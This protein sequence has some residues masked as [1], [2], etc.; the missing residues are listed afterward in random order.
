MVKL[1]NKKLVIHNSAVDIRQ[2]IHNVYDMFKYKITKGIAFL[3]DIANEIPKL[4]SIDE[5]RYIQI[6]FN[7]LSNACKF[8]LKGS[9]AINIQ[10]DNG[11]LYTRVIDTGMGI[12]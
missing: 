12:E 6:V 7:L 9:I 1:S 5:K 4:I 8:T 11:C 3:L 10:Y 2:V